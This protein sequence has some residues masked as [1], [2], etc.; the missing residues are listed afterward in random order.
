MRR[1]GNDAAASVRSATRVLD[2]LDVLQDAPDGMRLHE[3][4][5]RTAMP[6]STVL[7]YLGTLLERGYVDRDPVTGEYRLGLAVPS[8][9]QF[10]ARLSLAARPAM[11]RLGERF[12]EMVTF[13]VLDRDRIAFLDIIESPQVIRLAGRLGDRNYLHSSAIGKAVAATL[14]DD[15]VRRA[16]ESSGMPPLTDKTITDVDELL[17]ELERVRTR[18]YAV[19]DQENDAGARGI[20]VALPTT[21]VHG[22][23]GIA[24]P[25]MRFP[26]EQA[27]TVAVALREAAAEV[28]EAMGV[29]DPRSAKT[30]SS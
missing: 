3:L 26:L 23:L 8:Q 12:G 10:F 15:L 24:A 13:G 20:A 27:E 18:G 9:A 30:T 17:R 6:K 1:D 2:L 7:R 4:S 21:R 14:P 25:A 16:L 11:Q 5:L 19:A 28:A 22:G 29:A